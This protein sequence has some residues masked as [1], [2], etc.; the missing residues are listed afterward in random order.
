MKAWHILICAG[1][2]VVGGV[3]ADRLPRRV[4]QLHVEA[5]AE[6]VVLDEQ[7]SGHRPLLLDLRPAEQYASGHL[8]GAV[9]LAPR[10]EYRRR[11]RSAGARAPAQLSNSWI[12][13]APAATCARR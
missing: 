8:P 13:R 1:F 4:Q 6:A 5:L 3:W 9:H 10:L 12:A 2:V 7:V 11:A